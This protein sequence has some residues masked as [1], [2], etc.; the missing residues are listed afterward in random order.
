MPLA[1]QATIGQL[2]NPDLKT[3]K[4]GKAGRKRHLGIRP[5]VRGVVQNPHSHPHGGGEGKSGIGMPSP[6][7]PWGKK[8]LGKRTRK[9]TKHSDQLIAKRRKK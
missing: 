9:R 1:C 7:S 2:S 5:T 4:L 8:T 6:K 3:I